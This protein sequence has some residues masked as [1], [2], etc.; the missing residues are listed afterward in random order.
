MLTSRIPTAREVS[1]S[2]SC[3]AE[4]YMSPCVPTLCGRVSAC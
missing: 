4:D 3:A 2:H 1:V